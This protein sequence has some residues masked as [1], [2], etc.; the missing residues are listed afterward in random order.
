MLVV[1][2]EIIAA[3]FF[4]VSA[5][6][7][8]PAALR[9]NIPVFIG[10]SLVALATFLILAVD[11]HEKLY[12]GL[13]GG[14]W[15]CSSATHVDPV[16]VMSA[17]SAGAILRVEPFAAGSKFRTI[18]AAIDAAKPG[19]RIRIVSGVYNEVLNVSKPIHL[20]P[21]E[22]C[23]VTVRTT[24]ENHVL[25]WM[26]EGGSVSDLRFEAL[27]NTGNFGVSIS[28]GAVRMTNIRAI[29]RAGTGIYAYNANTRLHL[30]QS[31]SADACPSEPP[32]ALEG[33][34]A[35]GLFV[36]G[37]AQTLVERLS[38]CN[39]RLR[40][41]EINGEGSLA[42]LRGVEL[43]GNRQSGLSVS[44]QGAAIVSNGSFSRNGLHGVEVHYEGS[45]VDLRDATISENREIG[46]HAFLGGEAVAT[47]GEIVRNGVH[48]V[49]VQNKG[50]RAKL[51][52]LTVTANEW[53]GLA[54]S[55]GGEAELQ[56]V[57]ISGNKGGGVWAADDA[58]NIVED[59]VTK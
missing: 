54:V 31:R 23:G 40:G 35:S 55:N 15:K 16:P 43:S 34:G 14:S 17:P 36:Y 7:M 24:G 20:E 37:G 59:K 28:D 45:R 19:D 44:D 58:G 12:C 11:V 30:R 42:D 10:A 27:A 2:G 5:G 50:S 6:A 8:V 26:A 51:V 4:V 38:V 21:V 57:D 41:I 25:S 9:H 52:G 48:G 22:P 47:G 32:C 53:Y 39:N 33:S 3:L 49:A 56:E 1:L 13:F 29:S 46:V 18:Q